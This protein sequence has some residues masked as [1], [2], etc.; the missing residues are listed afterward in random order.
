MVGEKKSSGLGR[1]MV[2]L[3]GGTTT[4]AATTATT[5]LAGMH[6]KDNKDGSNFPLKKISQT[7]VELFFFSFGQT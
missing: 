6:F 7:D 5:A 2:F 1:K 3:E 4:T